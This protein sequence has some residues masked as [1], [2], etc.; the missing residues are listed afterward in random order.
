MI[1]NL[2]TN[3]AEDEDYIT[4]WE[5]LNDIFPY[6]SY[7]KEQFFIISAIQKA[8]NKALLIDAETGVG[9]TAAVISAVLSR[10]E[11]DERILIFTKMLGQMDAWFR[12]LGLINDYNRKIKRPAYT[13]LP[14]VGKNHVCP[15]VTRKTQKQFSQ[16][17]CQLFDCNQ[18]A[19]YH[20]FKNSFEEN[21]T[22][23]KRILEAIGEQIKGGVDLS[24]ILWLLQNKLSPESC[25]YQSIKMALKQADL[26]IT[27]YPFLLNPPYREFLF[28]QMGLDLANTTII[29]DEAHNLA[30]GTFGELSY[31]TLSKAI[32]EIGPHPLF[33]LLLNYKEKAGLHS[34]SIPEVLKTDLLTK[35][36]RFLKEQFKKGSIDISS[37]L[38]VYDFVKNLSYC[39]LTTDRK[40]LL[41][42]KDPREI[43]Q[44][45]QWVKQL[46]LLS[47]TLRPLRYFADFFGVP[48]ASKISVVSEKANISRII[49]TTSDPLMN[50][51]FK[52][53]T[54]KRFLYY[55]QAIKQLL[56]VIP[57]H[58]LIFT[59]NYELTAVFA[60]TLETAF[61]E[62][63]AQPISKLIAQVKE[64]KK[65]VVIIAPAR[66]KISE[67][68]EFVKDNKSIISAVIIAGLPFPPPSRS[69]SEIIQKYSRFW[70]EYRA[71]HFMTTLQ[72]IV[73]VRQ[74]L[75][76]MI[77]SEKD[78]GAWIIL[79]SRISS[80]GVFPRAIDCKN[81]RKMVE[82]LAYFYSKKHGNEK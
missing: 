23:P 45:F 66:G 47:G 43:L 14:L 72:A 39:Y 22:F 26:V 18:P 10:K 1:I 56:M 5:R 52:E 55:T 54:R 77:R 48:K 24:E 80:M 69:L 17:G 42:L 79:D 12:E 64:S 60:N 65:A 82:H 6:Q 58:T 78:R 62:E 21:V 19:R 81:T 63:P 30:K 73:T 59:P 9:K 46:I 27:T 40:F 13:L 51:R 32:G 61:V 3:I 33:D 2:E 71:R 25:P 49:L 57:G 74:A 36:K 31:R 44:P 76:R 53:R 7:R 34:L 11:K 37:S 16:I 20:S 50:M 41:Y 38:L 28:E 8:T 35:G 75:G 67:G 15:L 70:G 4:F 29:I 68:I